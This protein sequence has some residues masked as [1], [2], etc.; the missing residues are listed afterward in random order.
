MFG[1]AFTKP[2]RLG[3]HKS[4]PVKPKEH[5][6]I[7]LGSLARFRSTSSGI[8]VLIC[9]GWETLRRTHEDSLAASRRIC[10]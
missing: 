2:L 8:G 6:W 10:S 4:Y 7:H 5:S 3:G 1:G 9:G